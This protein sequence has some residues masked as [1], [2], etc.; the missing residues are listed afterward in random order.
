MKGLEIPQKI[1]LPSENI[2]VTQAK[3]Y[4]LSKKDFIDEFKL[5]VYKGIIENITIKSDNLD[6]IKTACKAYTRALSE[7]EHKELKGSGLEEQITQLQNSIAN[8]WE[9]PLRIGY[10]TNTPYKGDLFF[11]W[12]IKEI[13]EYLLK[14][15]DIDIRPKDVIY[16]PRTNEFLGWGEIKD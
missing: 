15:L 14:R 13:R 6:K 10:W 4:D 8:E 16:L 1:Y 3:V 5:E 2:S 12:R 7:Y 11:F 9:I